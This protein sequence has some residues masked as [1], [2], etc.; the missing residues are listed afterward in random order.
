M[1]LI[2]TR[3]TVEAASFCNSCAQSYDDD[4][5]IVGVHILIQTE[6]LIRAG[7]AAPW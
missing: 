5:F 1:L 7:D 4:V 2:Q 3:K 6:R